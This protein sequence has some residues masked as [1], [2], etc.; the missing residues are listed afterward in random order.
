MCWPVRMTA[1]PLS[2]RSPDPVENTGGHALLESCERIVE[3]PDPGA[4]HAKARQR[5]PPLL[6]PRSS[7]SVVRRSRRQVGEEATSSRARRRQP[8]RAAA[9]NAP[10]RKSRDRHLFPEATPV[11][12]AAHRL[13]SSSGV[14]SCTA[15]PSRKMTPPLPPGGDPRESR[16]TRISPIRWRPRSSGPPRTRPEAHLRE[17]GRSRIAAGYI[18]RLQA[19]HHD[20]RAPAPRPSRRAIREPG[21]A[22][23]E[24]E[25]PARQLVGHRTMLDPDNGSALA[26]SPLDQGPKRVGSLRS[27]P[28]QGLVEEQDRGLECQHPGELQSLSLSHANWPA[29]RSESAVSSVSPRSRSTSSRAPARSAAIPTFARTVHSGKGLGVWNVLARPRRARAAAPRG[30]GTPSKRTAPSAAG[31]LPQS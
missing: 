19:S 25:N 11:G 28:G 4:R 3:Q 10:T 16:A 2:G 8:R 29:G 22:A 30:A 17:D 14:R 5:Q 21:P 15:S 13:P 27:Q 31:S 20:D 23:F 18:A 12:N 26:A 9:R 6:P 7:D 1:A 24:N